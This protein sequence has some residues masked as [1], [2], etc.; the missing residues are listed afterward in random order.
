VPTDI[1]VD[2][3]ATVVFVLLGSLVF[4]DARRIGMRSDGVRFGPVAWG[5]LTGL[6]PFAVFFYAFRRGRFTS[7]RY[8]QETAA[9]IRASTHR[10]F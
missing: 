8:A 10:E 5:V 3:T 9:L 4:W 1:G 7:D 6:L 2:W